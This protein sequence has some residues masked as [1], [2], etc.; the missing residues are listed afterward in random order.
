[1][2]NHIVARVRSLA[3]VALLLT[4]CIT[5]LPTYSVSAE[6]QV[7]IIPKE[8]MQVSLLQSLWQRTKEESGSLPQGDVEW[9]LETEM[10]ARSTTVSANELA[11]DIEVFR[12]NYRAR[13]EAIPYPSYEQAIYSGLETLA[14]F[15]RFKNELPDIVQ[16]L[17]LVPEFGPN[18]G[19][20]S[21]L[22][23]SNGAALFF[24]K[25][26]FAQREAEQTR[27]A[28]QKAK[29]DPKFVERYDMVHKDRLGASITELDDVGT[30]IRDHPEAVIPP[31]IVQALRSDGSVAISLAEL[32]ELA[33]TEF[34]KINASIDDLQQTVDSINA[35]QDVLLD[36]VLDERARQE[37]QA[38]AEAKANE[39]RLKL[40]VAG[41]AINIVSTLASYIDPEV[42][43]QIS[44]IG[45]SAL[46]I[47]EAY[48]SWSKA[49]AG[50]GTL[51]ALGSLSTAAMTGNVI[52]AV[53]NVVSLFG[54]AQ[55]TP[56][57][58]IL[59]EIGK[60]RQQ[61]SELR[62][63]M[64][65]RFDR[66]DAQLN[67]IYTTL[68][69]RFDKIDLRLGKI[70]GDIE[71]VQQTLVRLEQT[72]SRIE[73]NSFEFLDATNRR[74]LLNAINGGLGYRERTGL[75]MPYQPDFLRYEND[76]HS[77]GTLF[78]FDPLS[79]GPS[80][81]DYSDG[82]VLA[83]LSAYPLDVNINYLNGW[84]VANGMQPFANK[85]LPGPRDWLFASRAYAQLALEWPEH[86]A[87]IH[88]ERQASLAAVG[89]EL[90]QAMQNISTRLTADGPQGNMP[91][92]TE[93]IS[94]Y[95]EKIERV[96]AAL[97]NTQTTF[98]AERANALG[99]NV[100]FDLYG[101]VDQPMAYV[102]PELT[103]IACGSPA[104]HGSLAAPHNL[105]QIVPNYNRVTLAEYLKL[106][107]I[108]VCLEG[109]NVEQR[110]E[111][112]PDPTDP[113]DPVGI[114]YN[115]TKTQA[116]LRVFI[117]NVEV[118][119]RSVTPPDERI[120]DGDYTPLAFIHLAWPSYK[121]AFETQ[122][123]AA[124][125]ASTAALSPT[126]SKQLAATTSQLEQALT[127]LQ[128]AFNRRVLIEVGNGTIKDEANE[129]AGAKKLLESFVA[130]G[131]P[132]ALESDDLLR[133][134]LYSNQALV[135]DQQV[136]LA[137]SR[138]LSSTLGTDEAASPL[139]LTF[140]PR[141]AL[142]ATA[143]K[144]HQ[145][146]HALLSRYSEAISAET[147]SE[148]INLIG[149]TR[150]RLRLAHILAGGTVDEPPP[151]SNRRL[152]LPLVQR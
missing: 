90:E 33:R 61:V 147:Y 52:S 66:V 149:D 107:V 50:L 63:E 94:Y 93:V 114:C 64:H 140:N 57:Q 36:Y 68:Q 74:P 150:L 4:F 76:F 109:E 58:M 123:A 16:F 104:D 111:C 133:S 91:L 54:P 87:Q 24:T 29:S 110:M 99:H 85:G 96:E 138:P 97:V 26:S 28:V 117:D 17:L 131:M 124:T 41:S 126:A 42:G 88:P 141:V 92:F 81:R 30:F 72:L 116:T 103:T 23:I 152:F 120:D 112:F 18:R 127:D 34:G 47:A 5:L 53:L 95:T 130:L 8:E 135:D 55:P 59:E 118:A 6:E 39:H 145:A 121:A 60:L 113:R 86:A 106:S 44:V 15:P 148:P 78:A 21:K 46:Q 48:S 115:Y 51:D 129:L 11:R 69:D 79:A 101:G 62:T 14:Q 98:V 146:L 139:D 56:E 144:R 75:A 3:C 83:E 102:A 65:D 10:A 35:K 119:V 100:G 9:L 70:E 134:L 136:A 80:Q 43:K 67:T 143:E 105:K 7:V 45:N 12:N 31:K 82:A 1:V 38:L 132:Q 125:S 84:L 32:N 71:E 13:M 137:Y 77:W 37:A 40:Q 20:D 2:L 151:R 19:F 108:K 89:Q 128:Q 122:F 22:Q 142:L 27:R 73:R 49:V 25:Q